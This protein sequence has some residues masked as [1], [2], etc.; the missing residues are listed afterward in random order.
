LNF[1]KEQGMFAIGS[2]T[3]SGFLEDPET[4]SE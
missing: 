2:E 4:S 3:N 1:D